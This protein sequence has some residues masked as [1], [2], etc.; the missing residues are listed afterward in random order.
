MLPDLLR[1][2]VFR[3]RSL[4]PRIAPTGSRRHRLLQRLLRRSG[5]ARWRPP[6]VSLLLVVDG[7]PGE[8]DAAVEK[9]IASLVS[10]SDGRWELVLAG[11]G[12]EP[13]RAFAPGDPRVRF[14]PT[15][16]DTAA[17]LNLAAAAAR[18]IFVGAIAAGDEVLPG[19][20]R[21]MTR[22][23]FGRR[24]DIVY[25]D[26]ADFSKPDWS[27]DLLL[28]F[29]YIGRL[30]LFGRG[31]I[32]GLGGWR[33][34]TLAAEDYRLLLAAARSGCTVRRVTRA[35]YRRAIPARTALITDDAIAARRV[36]LE[37]HLGALS[38]DAAVLPDPGYPGLRVRWAVHGEPLVSIVIATRDRLA[39]LQQCITSI[40]RHSTYA[41]REIVIVDND[42]REPETLEY[43]ASCGHRVVRSSG[44]FN[45]ARINNDGARAAGGE[46]VIFLNND[47]EV[48]TPS[49]IEEMLQHAQ[50]PGV[51]SVGAKLLFGDGR[52]QHAGVV[53]HDGSAYHLAYAERTS[54]TTWPSIELTRNVS[55]VTAACLMINRRHFL[56]NGG[57]DESFPVNYNDVE[58]GVR[59]LRRGFRHVYSPHAVLFHHES[60][61]RTPGVAAAEGR[62]LRAACGAI[63]WNDPFCPRSEVRGTPRWTLHPRGGETIA[64]GMR[65]SRRAWHALRGARWRARPLLGIRASSSEPEGSDAIRWIDRLEI[66]GD[67]RAALFMHPHARRT[68]AMASPR[69]GQF[70][71]WI[72]L[73]PDAWDRNTGGVNF[74]VSVVAGGR[75]VKT[76]QWRI[77][78]GGV[79][80]HRRWVPV[81]LTFGT[82]QGEPIELVLE[83]ETPPDAGPQF[84][85]A[86]WGDPAIAERQ[87]TSAIVQRHVTTVRQLGPRAAARRYARLL[88]GNPGQNFVLYDAWFHEQARSAQ[89]TPEHLRAELDALK[90]K[91]LISILTPVYNTPPELFA[92]MVQ[93]VRDQL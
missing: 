35:V 13:Y 38:A 52:V 37:E 34:D 77:D 75:T 32:A 11:D 12:S 20:I 93:S 89:R 82:P 36:A 81:A 62:H 57:F 31:V 65:V 67:V 92:R 60:S 85:W 39:L 46:Y 45:F 5:R 63:L 25:G 33:A 59:L 48:I 86:V 55:A 70:R 79:R 22:A 26:E 6:R 91:P 56:D 68:F 9:T 47:T 64:R 74:R 88:R 40:E 1:T 41:A 24:V 17:R 66:K 3:L 43:F 29:P 10:Q 58:L 69:G 19:G 80:G 50:R 44:A 72:A 53:L 27:P 30:C 23:V 83:T 87:T 18:G 84:G 78:P 8:H 49:W 54:E 61:S 15:K 71:A 90:Y 2:I 73:M 76:R 51:A 7:A 14:V 4:R 42:S 16:G 28:A 21:A